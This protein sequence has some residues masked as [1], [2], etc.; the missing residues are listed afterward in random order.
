M[1]IIIAVVAVIIVIMG[2]ILVKMSISPRGASRDSRDIRVVLKGILV[3][4][5]WASIVMI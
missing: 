1:V 4:S 5:I 2:I 3:P